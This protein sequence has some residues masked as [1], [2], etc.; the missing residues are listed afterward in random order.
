[1]CCHHYSDR[2]TA[3]K[4][5]AVIAARKDV[6]EKG[7][8]SLQCQPWNPQSLPLGFHGRACARSLYC[9]HD[10][11]T[12]SACPHPHALTKSQSQALVQR[13]RLRACHRRGVDTGDLVHWAVQLPPELSD[14]IINS[15]WR[16]RRLGDNPF[17]L[18]CRSRTSTKQTYMPLLH[19]RSSL[20]SAK[21][22]QRSLHAA[23]PIC[24]RAVDHHSRCRFSPITLQ[25]KLW[26]FFYKISHKCL[27]RTSLQ[28]ETKTW[29]HFITVC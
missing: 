19:Q 26:M 1:M 17:P 14:V 7:K 21:H 5:S 25:H 9:V 3:D 11:F 27:K 23:L 13:N 29:R 10:I 28:R 24:S 18:P 12:S 16:A 4:Q 22:N 8:Y 2:H 15:L 20:T 6:R